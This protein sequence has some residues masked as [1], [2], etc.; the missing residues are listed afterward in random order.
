MWILE[1]GM[2]EN[3]ED[4]GDSVAGMNEQEV[5]RPETLEGLPEERS[6]KCLAEEET[7]E[8]QLQTGGLPDWPKVQG[9]EGTLHS[10]LVGMRNCLLHWF[11][12]CIGQEGDATKVSKLLARRQPHPS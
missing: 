6:T 12:R 8:I 7:E 3:Q 1:W 2:E 11:P 9:R 4:A 10:Q 5:E